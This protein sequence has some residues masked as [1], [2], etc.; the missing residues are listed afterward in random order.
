MHYVIHP[1]SDGHYLPSHALGAGWERHLV[2]LKEGDS[3]VNPSST[4]PENVLRGPAF[5]VYDRHTT[6][7]T[8]TVYA[9]PGEFYDALEEGY[10]Q[11]Q[12]RAS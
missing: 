3:A 9:H 8:T 4:K 6:G 11:R 12:E 5:V 10:R 2:E 7:I 1:E